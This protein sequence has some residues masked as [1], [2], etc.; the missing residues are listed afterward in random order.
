VK[1]FSNNTASVALPVSDLPISGLSATNDSP[2][3][4]GS[5]A[6]FTA[7]AAGSN[8]TYQWNFG[9]GSTATGVTA[10]HAFQ[11]IGSGDEDRSQTYTVTL[12]VTDSAGLQNSDSQDVEVVSGV[13]AVFTISNPTDGS[14]TVY[15][16]A[17]ESR[18]SSNGFG[19][20]NSIS[21]YIWHFGDSNDLEEKTSPRTSHSFGAAGTYRVTLTVEDS[22]GRRE[23]SASQSFT[24]AN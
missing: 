12:T 20:R 15:F 6:T 3:L 14:L 11:S 10:S 19:G 18:G 16:N 22:A 2:T 24:V 8:V 1:K 4:L 7:T 17:E 21:K 5:A 23:V 13:S 9:D